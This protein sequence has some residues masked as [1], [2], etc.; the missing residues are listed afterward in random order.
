MLSV[1]FV[2]SSLQW[3]LTRYAMTTDLILGDCSLLFNILLFASLIHRRNPCSLYILAAS[4]SGFI[5]LNNSTIPVVYAMDYPNPTTASALFCKL[6]FYL[7]H[8]FNQMM[9]TFFIFVCADR[10]AISSH[11]ARIQPLLD[12]SRTTAGV[13]LS[14]LLLPI[15]LM[16]LFTLE[17]GRYGGRPG[18]PDF[19]VSIYITMT[20]GVVPLIGLLIFR[21]LM[22][23]NLQKIRLRVQPIAYCLQKRDGD[24]MKM[25][26]VETI[27]YVIR[28]L[29]LST[30]LLDQSATQ[31]R[32]KSREQQR[33]E[34][35]VTYFNGTFLI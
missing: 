24:M 20:V 26:S 4:I 15:F 13:P 8:S 28:A 11:N 17:N 3:Y 30:N 25:L 5:S 27:L 14:W 23:R 9:R 21:I 32:V 19:L 18:L 31:A 29:S 7:R 10:F 34:S 12:S 2:L 35:F 16:I 33:I 1:G 6:Q 22:W